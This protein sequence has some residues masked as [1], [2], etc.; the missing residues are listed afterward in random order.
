M[1]VFNS[2]PWIKLF[3]QVK[4]KGDESDGR[5]GVGQLLI[6]MRTHFV[7]VKGKN[8]IIGFTMSPSTVSLLVCVQYICN[9]YNMA[10]RYL[11]DICPTQK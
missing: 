2:P 4:S 8:S 11:P 6:A 9:S 3:L 5:R 10:M 1:P 7:E